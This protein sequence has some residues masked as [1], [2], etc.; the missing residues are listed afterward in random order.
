MQVG[1]APILAFAWC[2]ELC[3]EKILQAPIQTD[4]VLIDKIYSDNPVYSSMCTLDCLEALTNKKI[5]YVEIRYIENVLTERENKE[6]LAKNYRYKRFERA[7]DTQIKC[8]NNRYA[9]RPTGAPYYSKHM[10]KNKLLRL[11]VTE[12]EIVKPTSNYLLSITRYDG[13]LPLLL[14]MFISAP[15]M[16][17]YVLTNIQNGSTVAFSQYLEFYGS[18]NYGALIAPFYINGQILFERPP[19]KLRLSLGNVLK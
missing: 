8:Y 12:K 2:D 3:G 1:Y 4:S 17:E 18:L 5:K 19:S 13:Q 16:D 10:I 6:K 11:C 9:R 15:H 7:D 14:A